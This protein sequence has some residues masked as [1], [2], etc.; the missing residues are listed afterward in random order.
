M[1]LIT[2]RSASE[3][4]WSAWLV[5]AVVSMPLLSVWLGG[6]ALGCKQSR[7]YRRRAKLGAVKGATLRRAAVKVAEEPSMLLWLFHEYRMF[8]IASI[9][10]GHRLGRYK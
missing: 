1:R 5:R 2:D 10:T 9:S 8:V 3:P 7:S 4:V 6:A